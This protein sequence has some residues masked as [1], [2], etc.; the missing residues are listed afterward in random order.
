[1]LAELLLLSGLIA[2]PEITPVASVP[3]AE[4]QRVVAIDV[5]RGSLQDRPRDAQLLLR[6]LNLVRAAG[7]L[8]PLAMEPRLC[9]LAREHA[10]D[11]VAHR[12]FGHASS[13]GA[14][15]FQRM[16]RAGYEYR[17]AGEN[18]AL[19]VDEPSAHAMLWRSNEHRANMLEPQFGHV[20]IAALET[21]NGEIFVEDFSD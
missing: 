5:G 1:M 6:D 7:G 8:T 15:P 16:R 9:E 2:A 12:F 11:M 13:D 3:S 4:T 17:A 18:L 14:S 20:G 21:A 19:D 10:L